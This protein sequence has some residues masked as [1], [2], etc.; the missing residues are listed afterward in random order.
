V[1]LRAHGVE[2]F[3]TRN[4]EDFEAFGLFEVVDPIVG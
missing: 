1:T 4:L 2:R 3:F